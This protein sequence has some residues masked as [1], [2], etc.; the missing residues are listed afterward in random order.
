MVVLSFLA[1]H[2][3]LGIAMKHSALVATVHALLTLLVG[4]YIAA[5]S[6]QVAKVVMAV[7]YLMA[8]EVLWRVS[9]A[10]VFWEYGK[11]ATSAILLLWAARHRAPRFNW[12][13]IVYLLLL[14][15]SI[16]LTGLQASGLNDFR[17][18]VSGNFSGPFALVVCA[19][20]LYRVQLK[21]S[22]YYR[23][24]VAILGPV[25]ALA[26]ICSF[27]T[28]TLEAGYEFSANSNW[29]TSGGFGPNQVSAVLG[30][31]TL[32][33]FLWS[34]LQKPTLGLH[35]VANGLILWFFAQAALTF[36]RTGVFLG[37]ITIALASAFMLRNQ[38]QFIYGLAA[39]AVLIA[40]SYFLIYPALDQFTGGLLTDRYTKKELLTHRDDI[41]RQD[42][43][44]ALRHPILGVGVGVAR[45]ARTELGVR[46]YACHTEFTRLLAEH[47]VLGLFALGALLL[48]GLLGVARAATPYQKAWA[49]SLMAYG[50]L[51]MTVSGMRLEVPAA[52]IGLAMI[53]FKKRHQFQEARPE[54]STQL[55]GHRRRTLSGVFNP[56]RSTFHRGFRAMGGPVN[57]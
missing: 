57:R 45:T 24:L 28:A 43:E 40:L 6:R 4:L 47:G 9:E 18:R 14:I 29:D 8:A 30:F 36:S 10:V 31:G 3:V 35:W 15:P 46:A 49:I 44:L 16:A 34:K 56:R 2:A 33:A 5:T 48:M 54:T 21:P 22:D 53:R 39:L 32:A 25:V 11:Y 19:F 27:S 23:V 37:I 26:A 42:L 1:G 20:V 51:F 41:A 12:L 13:A 17:Q 7:S 55:A 52:A 38:R 50:M